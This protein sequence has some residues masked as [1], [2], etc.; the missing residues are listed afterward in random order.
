MPENK[1]LKLNNTDLALHPELKGLQSLFHEDRLRPIQSVGY[2]EQNF[3]HFRST[4][5]WMS[6]SDSSQ[7]V[8]SGWVGR[9]LSQDHPGFPE[10]YPNDNFADPLS[11][12]IGYSSSLIFQG[13]SSPMNLVINDPNHFYE[14][15]DEVE[16][17]LPSGLAGEKLRH[18]RLTARQSQIYGQVVKEAAGKGRNL[19]SYPNNNYL[20][21]QLRIV[22]RLISGGLKTPLYLVTLGGFDTHDAQVESNDH[23]Q[24]EHANLLRQLDEAIMSFLRDLEVQGADDRVLGMTFSEFG[25]R[26]VSNASLGTDHGSAAPMFVFGNNVIPGVLGSNPI[27]S[28]DA[29]YQDNLEMQHD[30]RAVYASILEQWFGKSALDRQQILL[31]DFDTLPILN[32]TVVN[33]NDIFQKSLPAIRVYPNPVQASTLVEVQANGEAMRIDLLNMQG[34]VLVPLFSGIL[35]KG[36]QQIS[37]SAGRLPAGNYIVRMQQAGRFQ[38]VQVVKK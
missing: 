31:Q 6:A 10:A 13:P 28:P 17:P 18:I 7:L 5:I 22:A 12:E 19:V 1:L 36:K 3:S 33:T 34:Q 9:H 35:P 25:R 26:I 27:I 23:T 11:I 16:G 8:N 32:N 37:W 15:V 24:G 29:T 21:E 4:D 30:F 14:L 20:A 2:P 38:S